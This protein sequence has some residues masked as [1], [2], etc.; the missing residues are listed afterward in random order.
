M[1]AGLLAALAAGAAAYKQG[2]VL[3]IFASHV[4]PVANPSETYPFYVL[5]YCQPS[6][7]S[8]PQSQDLGESLSGDQKVTT[9]YEFK[10]LQNSDTMICEKELTEE[11]IDRFS[12]A[13]EEE[14]YG[15]LFLE[16]MPMWI[17]VGEGESEDF[18]LGH[19]DKSRHYLYTHFHFTVGYNGDK[20]VSVNVTASP[21]HRADITLHDPSHAIVPDLGE[22]KSLRSGHSHGAGGH[23]G[24]KASGPIK[25]KFGYSVAFVPSTVPYDQRM[26]VYEAST[27]MPQT[28]EIHWLSIL[29]SLVL[30]LLLTA[31]LGIILVRVVKNDFTRYMRADEDD[32]SAEEE[33]GWKLVHG[34]VFRSPENNNLFAAMVGAG[35]HLFVMVLALLTL[36]VLGTFSLSRRGSI[37]AACIVLYVMSAFVGGYIS[38]RSYRR[39]KGTNWVWNVML[40]LVMLPAPLAG[41]FI[42]LNATAT[43]KQSTA[44]LPLGTVL[45]VLALFLF[46]G[47][48]LSVLGGIA[49]HNSKEFEP[50]CRVS[51]VPRQIPEVP[52]YRRAPAQLFMAGFLPFSAI[53]IELHYIF[54]SLWGHKVYTLY[55][56][57][58]LAF[59][60]LTVVTAF[61]TIALTYFQLA[62]EDH[63]WWWR[64]FLS[65]GSVGLF[66]YAYCFFYYFNHSGMTGFLQTAFYFL[67]MANVSF[68]FFLM[69]GAIGFYAA[70]L[71]VRYIYSSIKTD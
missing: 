33:S 66:I 14:W 16:D 48:P 47:F 18:L 29:N 59:G 19:T 56:I 51:K 10:F 7:G 23:E 12:T 46:I 26:T 32:E 45:V 6:K 69:M 67:Y 62:A 11:E 30:V 42:I 49:G 27:A 13:I 2:D 58:F 55:G 63:R 71:F 57:L 9:P 53:S 41:T 31:F 17:Y 65:G 50:P 37:V 3:K 54:A 60:L 61:I 43:I 38:A 15:E 68:A 70:F 5:P 25:V 64:S 1:R 4:G 39:L 24:G 20:V 8:E 22:S 36:A 34:D 44:A 40:N 52:A 28:L 35:V 21:D